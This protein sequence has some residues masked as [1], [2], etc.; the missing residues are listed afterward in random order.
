MSRREFLGAANAAA[1]LLL[2]ESCSLGPIARGAASPSIPAGRTAYEQGLLLLRQAVRASPDHLAQRA[3]DLVTSRDATKIANFVRDRIA[4]VPG[5]Y[6]GD[7][8]NLVRRW[9][10][11][12]TLRGG[13]GTLRER[14]D[15]LAD[16]LTRAGFPASV[17]TA[18]RPA[19]IDLGQLYRLRT[20]DFAP[21]QAAIDAAKKVLHDAGLPAPAAPQPF[22]AGPDPVQSILSALPAPLQLARVRSDLLPTKVPVVV[23]DDGGKKRYAFA[24]GDL[25]IADTS[26][27]GLAAAGDAEP[28]PAVKITVS[29]LSNPP[30]GSSTPRGKLIDLV[31]GHWPSDMIVGRQ[32][33]LTF[34]PVQG[35][36]SILDSGLSA[37]PVRIPTLRVQSDVAPTSAPAAFLVAGSPITVQGDVLAPPQGANPAASFD[38]PFGA[39]QALSDTD[40]KSAVARAASIR[41][42]ANATAFPEVAVDFVVSDSTGAPV[43]GIDAA[44]LVVKEQGSAVAGFTLY[45]NVNRQPRPRVLIVYDAKFS[46]GSW[47]SAAAENKFQTALGSAIAGQS[48]ATPFDVQVIGLGVPPDPRAWSAPQAA[49]ITSALKGAAESLD[50]PWL[51]VGGVALDQGVSAIVLVSDHDPADAD[52]NALPT[53]QRRLVASRVP[54]FTVPVGNVNEAI[55]TQIVSL[56]G[57]ARLAA[58]DPTTPAKI[59]SL[60][61]PLIP[62]WVGG[63]YRLRYQAPVAGPSQRTVTIGLA[64]RAQPVGSATYQVPDKP[65]PPPSFVGLYVTIE[66]QGGLT[67]FRRLVGAE[68]A[69]RGGPQGV[70]DDP[71]GVAATRAAINGVT[72]IAFEPGT[73]TPAALLDDVLSSCLSFEPLRA[74]W[75][76]GVTGDKLVKALGNG[77]RRTPGILASMLRPTAIDAG[78]L[79]VLKVAILQERASATSVEVHADLAVGL[80]AVVPITA[81]RHAAFRSAVATSVGASAAEAAAFAD[82]AYARLSGRHL[83]TLVVSDGAAINAFLKTVPAEKVTAWTAMTRI[84]QDFHILAPDAGGADAFWLVDPDTGIAKAVFLDGTGGGSIQLACKLTATDQLAIA[85]ATLAIFCSLGGGEAFPFECIE[86]N[87]AAVVMTVAGLFSNTSDYKDPGAPFA[88]MLGVFNPVGPG[89]GA[90]L[91]IILIMIT[92]QAA[93]CA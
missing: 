85:F 92:Y 70:L 10:L 90:G 46:F 69:L 37:L 30:A 81:D 42:S 86:I 65:V 34:P 56:S 73:P 4:V 48:A 53:L 77:V 33:L 1:L 63:A 8:A 3:A 29:A 61:A 78:G 75:G 49:A 83:T 35:P 41:A 18:N 14:A 68:V 89:L 93:G 76:T 23:F 28:T 38:G 66:V 59:A 72:T 87:T 22:D 43:D 21:D 45:S 25:P 11:S 57:G 84:Y 32:V 24:L 64:G 15:V 9:G 71:V 5:Q 26:P 19:A 58:G 50:D 60:I 17:S 40:R 82:S 67:S 44:S 51:T 54:V 6:P 88:L 31:S 47:P 7:D 74:V 62:K 27:A 2:L 13:Q 80:N 20:T 12:A 36:K 55:V 91:G 79:P 16:M 39:I 52:P